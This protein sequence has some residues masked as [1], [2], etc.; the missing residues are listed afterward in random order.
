[1]GVLWFDTAPEGFWLTWVWLYL[2][3]RCSAKCNVTTPCVLCKAEC[4][5]E[6]LMDTGSSCVNSKLTGWEKGNAQ[7]AACGFL[8]RL[9]S[10]EWAS[11]KS[12]ERTLEKVMTVVNVWC[13][14]PASVLCM[15][16][17]KNSIYNSLNL[18][19]RWKMLVY[20]WL[21]EN[22]VM[23]KSSALYSLVIFVCV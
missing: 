6:F 11:E 15:V 8:V 16:L 18:L 22:H 1:M 2:A 5:E 19:Q 23:G 3:W 17:V 14:L 12:L 7:G 10:F 20:K 9:P 4:S 13:L 21:I